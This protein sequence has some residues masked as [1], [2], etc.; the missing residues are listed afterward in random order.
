MNEVQTNVGLGTKYLKLVLDQV[1]H[2][3]LASTAYNA[4]PG[5]AR[6]WRDSKPLEGAV[7]VETIPF[8]ETRDYVKNVMAN[9][10]FY[11]AVLD[12]KLSPI[13]ARLGTVP[14]RAGTEPAV[15]DELP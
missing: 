1:G 12:N 13:K 6:R 9:S 2:P 15:E 5:R 11:A 8:S 4:G 7:Y 10:V 3:I 14:P